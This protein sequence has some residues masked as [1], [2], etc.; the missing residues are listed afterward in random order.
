M[1]TQPQRNAHIPWEISQESDELR[2][3]G[4]K[5]TLPR[6]KILRILAG[7]EREHLAAE[8][9]Y[10]RLHENGDDI[11][12]ATVYRVL[13]Q[14]AEVGIVIRHNFDS[15]RAVFELNS[16]IQHD[17]LV[18]VDCG[19]VEEFKDRVIERRQADVAAVS[20]YTLLSHSHI[21]YG[22]CPDCAKTPRVQG[23]QIS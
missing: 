8:E 16:G 6:L 7:R 15:D 10:Q 4:L 23:G 21:L 14:F 5:V 9:V 13:T 17:H 3:A 20:G 19:R 1:V 2:R 22:R 11:G 18:C 12:L